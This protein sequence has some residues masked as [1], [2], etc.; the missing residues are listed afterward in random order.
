MQ[1]IVVAAA[2]ILLATCPHPAGA[3]RD[4]CQWVEP[5][6]APYGPHGDLHAA[7]MRL[8]HIPEVH[9]RILADSVVQDTPAD[10]TRV[11]R[12]GLESKRWARLRN[13]NF[14][15]GR[16]CWGGV[17]TS[18]WPASRSQI[19]R[20][21]ASGPHAVVYL[22]GC[23]NIAEATDTWYSPSIIERIREAIG[24]KPRTTATAGRTPEPA[25]WALL[26]L[27]LAGVALSRRQK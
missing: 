11:T 23:G 15:G 20:I 16:I 4:V 18:M 9:R 27:A 26:G 19:A 1:K 21:H 22:P 7:V 14:T 5:G 3:A 12:D 2:I 13:M 24:V 8:E 10:V 6:A 17:D 25:T